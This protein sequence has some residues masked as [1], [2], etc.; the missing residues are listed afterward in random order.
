MQSNQSRTNQGLGSGAQA[1]APKQFNDYLFRDDYVEERKK[2]HEEEKDKKS[3]EGG[4]KASGLSHTIPPQNTGVLQVDGSYLQKPESSSA[5][6]LQGFRKSQG[7]N[8]EITGVKKPVNPSQNL[9]QKSASQQNQPPSQAQQNVG[10]SQQ[11]R[12]GQV[13]SSS[14]NI[15]FNS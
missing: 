5:G 9:A 15:W 13:G 11:P 1:N 3:A 14:Y 7:A 10:Y 4:N 8:P 6:N 2:M 12:P